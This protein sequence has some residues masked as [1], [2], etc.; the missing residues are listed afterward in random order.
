MSYQ[1]LNMPSFDFSGQAGV[2][3]GAGQ[4]IG[5]WIALALAKAGAGVIIADINGD[6][7]RKTC[8]EIEEFGGRSAHMEADMADP[9]ACTALMNFTRDHFGRLDFSVN[10]AGVNVHKKALEITPREFDFVTG[11]NA[12]GVY[13]CCQAAARIMI[14]QG[15]GKIVNTASAGGFLVRSGVPNSVYAMTKAGVIMLTKAL[16]EEWA[17]SRIN[18]NAVAPGYMETPLVADRLKDPESRTRILASTPL[19]KVGQAKDLV[20]AY[21]FLISGLSDYITGQTIFVDGGRTIL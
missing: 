13:F 21:L 3:T 14:A 1:E 6:A 7:A 10:N 5:K 19:Q 20:G 2:V 8:R 4:G 11:V 16:A 17:A 9:D 12:R 18:V 15:G